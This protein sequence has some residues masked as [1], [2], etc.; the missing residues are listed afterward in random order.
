[1]LSP[2]TKLFP[3]TDGQSW[4]IAPEKSVQ[5]VITSHNWSMIKIIID[6][7]KSRSP[8]PFQGV[9]EMYIGGSLNTCRYVFVLGCF[10]F[11]SESS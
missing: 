8:G 1:M 6:C 3:Y 9:K 4:R 7:D 11:V 2:P 5:S 10:M